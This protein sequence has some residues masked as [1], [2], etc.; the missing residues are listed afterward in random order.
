[1]AMPC[2]IPGCAAKPEALP[3]LWRAVGCAL[4]PVKSKSQLHHA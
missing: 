2:P 3:V 4:A 1:M